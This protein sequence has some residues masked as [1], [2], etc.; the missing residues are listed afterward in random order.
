MQ[1]IL[2]PY[3]SKIGNTFLISFSLVIH[4]MLKSGSS[5]TAV[6]AKEISHLTK[7]SFKANDMRIYRFFK[8]REFQVDDRLWRCHI[9]LLFRLM[10]ERNLLKSNEKVILKIDF[11]TLHDDFLILTA[12]I[13]F[14]GRS[15]PLFFTMRN[16]PKRAGS[17]DQKK[18]E[19]AFIKELKHLLPKKYEY[20]IVADRGF[21]NKRFAALCVKNGFDFVLRVNENLGIKVNE[22]NENL[23][24]YIGKPFD[25]KAFVTSWQENHR[26]VGCVSKD[27][28]WT[29]MTSLESGSETIKWIYKERFGIEKCFQDQKSSGFDIEKTK[30]RKYDRFKRVLFCVCL[31]QVLTVFLGEFINTEK[32]KFKKKYPIHTSLV[33]AYL[34]SDNACLKHFSQTP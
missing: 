34:N 15:I 10:K 31:A 13:D 33:L 24:L 20:I 4:G 1:T 21:G 16:Y 12:G 14:N 29:L 32:H 25:I 11:T 22:K 17:M 8:S 28:H 6:L 9:K 23:S 5:N 7:E 27:K 30:I 18:M 26:F 2:S 3:F 19:L